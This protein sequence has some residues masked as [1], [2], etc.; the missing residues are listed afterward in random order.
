MSLMESLLLTRENEDLKAKLMTK[1][2][3]LN[4]AI[5]SKVKVSE[6]QMKDIPLLNVCLSVCCRIWLA[7]KVSV[8]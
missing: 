3:E 2:D 5:N 8:S 6:G 1:T 4:D 7:R